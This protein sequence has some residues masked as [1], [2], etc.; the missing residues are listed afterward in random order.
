[1]PKILLL[2]L[3]CSSTLIFGEEIKHCFV[4]MDN[5]KSSPQLIY[6]DQV[7]PEKSWATKLP[8]LKGGTY[9]SIQKI[10]KNRLLINHPDG[11][12]EYDLETGKPL[13]WKVAGLRGVQAALR[14]PNGQTA[15]ASTSS[16]TFVDANGVTLSQKVLD[17]PPKGRVRV[18]TLTS[19]N[20]LL[21]S[22]NKPYSLCEM[23]LEG[24]LIK[25]IPLPDKGYKHLL[26]PN[27][28]SLNSTG[29]TCKVIE[30]NPT[31]E[32]VRYVGRKKEHPQLKLDFCSGWDQLD[33]GNIIMTNWLGHNKVG[34]A[35]QLFEFDRNNKLVWAWDGRNE[36]K[37][38]T[39]VLLLD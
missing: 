9:R 32:I 26:L 29:D 12:G 39:N 27:G 37:T 13:E 1:M 38:V 35:Q 10:D 22:S 6:V 5:Y 17:G 28:N 33:N 36:A 21:Y 3:F 4:V 14:L 16:I 15:I 7:D 19:R 2:L 18:L 11:A 8:V 24:E 31:G 23:S 30:M 20:T 34:T 25:T